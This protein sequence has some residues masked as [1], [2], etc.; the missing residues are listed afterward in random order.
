MADT[1]LNFD[2]DSLGDFDAAPD[3]ADGLAAFDAASGA[4]CVPAGT[5]T[6]TLEAGELVTTKAGKPAYRLR[7]HVVEPAAHAGFALWRYYVLTPMDQANKAKAAL[8]PLRLRTSAELQKSPFPEAGRTITCKVLVGLQKDD[9][10]R[11]DVLRFSVES[12]VT[13]APTAN[14]FAVPLDGTGEA[15][16]Q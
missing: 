1:P 10:T 14:P 15:A 2:P 11:N 8:A 6:A 13:G 9:P 16:T 3:P 5:Y 7:F 4:T 12:D